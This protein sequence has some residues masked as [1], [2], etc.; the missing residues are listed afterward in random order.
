MKSLGLQTLSL[1]AIDPGNRL[2]T[3]DEAYAQ[4][5]AD[6]IKAFG[7]LRQPIEVRRKGKRDGAYVLIAGGHRLRAFAQL[8]WTEIPAF[9]FDASE[10]EGRL[11]EIDENLIRHDLNPLDR[12]VFLYER[13]DIYLRLHPET[14]AGVAGAKARHGKTAMANLAIAAFAAC[15]ARDVR[16]RT[17][18]SDRAVRRAVEI[19][20]TNGPRY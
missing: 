3:I 18:M 5:L 10:E 7:G 14:A 13:K 19:A 4:L 1:T 2:R 6:N 8:G 15:F 12:A 9:V 20:H 16:E 11:A 17:G